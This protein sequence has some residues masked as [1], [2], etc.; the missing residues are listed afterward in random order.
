MENCSQLLFSKKEAAQL[1]SL[2]VRS[3][4]YLLT[5][6]EL[7]S[8][9]VGRKVL[10]PKSALTRFVGSDHPTRSKGKNRGAM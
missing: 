10:I 4:D 2:S 1:L 5:N 6:G 8:R 3:V 7:E 9:R